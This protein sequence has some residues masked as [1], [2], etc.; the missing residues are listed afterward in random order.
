LPFLG[1]KFIGGKMKGANILLIVFVMAI[2]A[3]QVYGQGPVDAKR[4]MAKEIADEI[5]DMRSERAASLIQSDKTVTPELFKEVCGA[6]K[7]RAM[8]LARENNVRIR[9]AAIKNRNPEHAA[10]DEERRL[11]SLFEAGST[12]DGIWDEVEIEGKGYG[13][14]VRPIFVEPACLACHGERDSRP[15][16]I[17]K[18]YPEDRAYGFKAGDLRGIIEVMVPKN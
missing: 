9:H 7:K 14:Y 1:K 15:G 12:V 3:G 5:S 16:F 17:Q 8:A 4:Q 18:K 13:R 6:V 11:H 2:S 10:T